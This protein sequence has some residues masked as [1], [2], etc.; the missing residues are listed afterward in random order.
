VSKFNVRLQ[1]EAGKLFQILLPTTE[2][3]L[4][5]SRVFVLGTVERE[6]YHMMRRFTHQLSAVLILPIPE[7]QPGWVDLGGWLN[8]GETYSNNLQLQNGN[9]NEEVKW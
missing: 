3:L 1:H 4:S 9:E 6:V 2:K 8:T 7:G 5:P